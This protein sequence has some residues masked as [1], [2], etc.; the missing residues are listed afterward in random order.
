MI[1]SLFGPDGAGKTTAASILGEQL[2][3][4][5]MSGTNIASWD[6]DSWH[7][8]FVEQGI[9]EGRINETNHFY[10]KIYR[11]H[12]EA[13][14]VDDIH[15]GV[16]L[17]SDPA[18]K[19]FIFQYVLGRNMAGAALDHELIVK[20]SP[21]RERLQLDVRVSQTGTV[22]EHA[23]ELQRRISKRGASFFDPTTIEASLAA[24][25]ASNELAQQL[26]SIGHKVVAVYSDTFNQSAV[27]ELVHS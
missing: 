7:Q 15:G 9:D 19:R 16:V 20:H 2:S 21:G 22:D 3:L 17:D 8:S 6:D 25:R 5:V 4:P 1:I 14:R 11:A 18:H 27:S 26:H 10:E 12:Q 24:I 23:F 13:A